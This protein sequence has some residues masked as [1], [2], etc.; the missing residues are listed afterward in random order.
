MKLPLCAFVRAL[1]FGLLLVLA[2]P[3]R[4]QQAAEPYPARPVK[5]I[6]PYPPGAAADLIGRILMQ[7]LSENPGGRFYVENQPGAGDT[8]GAG[9]AARSP[10]DG[11]TLLLINQDFIVQ[12]LVK[13]SVPYDPFTGFVPV[14]LIAFA[15]I[16]L[17]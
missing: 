1:V 16:K 3:S 15:P 6:V 11:Y 5:L 4:A 7:K 9:A 2:L 8:I 14:A 12:P 13:S 10:A 17:D